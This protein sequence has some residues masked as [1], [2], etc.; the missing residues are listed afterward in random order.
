MK[1]YILIIVLFV[2][3]LLF[4]Q[5]RWVEDCQL[6]ESRYEFWRDS[7]NGTEVS[8]YC[9][10]EECD[11]GYQIKVQGVDIN[12]EY[13]WS[14]PVIQN[15][16]P[17]FPDEAILTLDNA[18]NIY[19]Y[20]YDNAHP[21]S[22][23]SKYVQKISNTG[24]LMWG[25]AGQQIDLDSYNNVDILSDNAGGLYIQLHSKF[26]H[27]DETGTIIADWE[28]GLEL[29]QHMGFASVVTDSGS[30]AILK[31]V[32]DVELPGRYFQIVDGDGIELYPGDGLYCGEY[33]YGYADLFGIDDEFM[34]A[35]VNNDTIFCNKLLSNGEFLYSEPQILG[36]AG[37]GE[38]YYDILNQG[39]YYYLCLNNDDQNTIRVDKYDDTWQLSATG[40]ELTY[41]Y[42]MRY[43]QVKP[44]GN[45]LLL[46]LDPEYLENLILVEY[47]ESGE[48]I[49]P[50]I[51]WLE[52]M[53]NYQNY[54]IRGDQQGNCYIIDTVLDENDQEGFSVQILNND[55]ELVF[56]DNGLLFCQNKYIYPMESQ[57]ILLENKTAIFWIEATNYSSR[58][59]IQYVDDEG[60]TLLPDDGLQLLYN[61]DYQSYFEYIYGDEVSIMVK[62]T[63]RAGWLDDEYTHFHNI[64]LDEEPWLEWGETG[65]NWEGA[66]ISGD[67][68]A[69]RHNE[70]S[71]LFYWQNRH[72]QTR[73]QLI[74]DGEFMLPEDYSLGIDYGTILSITDNYCT[75]S[76]GSD[77]LLTRWDD[78][79]EPVWDTPVW[80]TGVGYYDGA[81]YE[82][83]Q[84]ENLVK[85]WVSYEGSQMQEYSWRIKK[86][87]ISSDGEKLLG[88]YAPMMLDNGDVK[89]R[90]FFQVEEPEQI[91]VVCGNEYELLLKY[92]SM[93]GEL[94]SDEYITFDE[95]E[96]RAFTDIYTQQSMLFIKTQF[97]EDRSTMSGICV[98]DLEGNSIDGLPGAEFGIPSEYFFDLRSDD[99]GIYYCWRT[100]HLQEE[101]YIQDGG[102]D[103][104]AQMIN[105]PNNGNT[106]E[107]LPS[108]NS[109]LIIYPNPF[110]PEVN[111]CWQLTEIND[112]SSLS[113]FNIKGQ[114]VRE[115]N[116]NTKAGQITWDGK[117]ASQQQCASGIYLLRLQSGKEKQVAK[118]LM[119]K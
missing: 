35:W 107:Q 92:M 67:L 70:D 68:H 98:Y 14:E 9:W 42:N 50:E 87:I 13:V 18:D 49:S 65:L 12:Q 6:T 61:N 100:L 41:I 7:V 94:I 48:L 89:I 72:E 4:A 33:S 47:N 96:G 110:N 75:Y 39:E 27:I 74:E 28:D 103:A 91:G 82:Y 24:E 86:Q 115:Y 11:T 22:L 81:S 99:N 3:S 104:Y 31:K 93:S 8:Y 43:V 5:I 37:D 15:A 20:W 116:V 90:D 77:I 111:I 80:L 25:D 16:G 26:W 85:Y 102:Y 79:F 97:N 59:M 57:I 109:G 55:S 60:N 1:L 40:S 52:I 108:V 64:K 23:I 118:I 119:M 44:D 117:D 56:A 58:I 114:K 54:S 17:E 10:A 36:E 38:H 66:E 95:L 46:V 113:I 71:I 21:D 63:G 62:E 84:G 78:D 76:H 2:S 29:G 19:L 101:Y 105:L 73:A 112:E 106:N 45:I 69:L 30:L 53:N 32:D 83:I 34:L 51:G 88:V